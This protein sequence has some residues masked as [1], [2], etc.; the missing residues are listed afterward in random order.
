MT[1][2]SKIIAETHTIIRTVSGC[3]KPA[4]VQRAITDSLQNPAFEKGMNV[5]WELSNADLS[6][7]NDNEILEVIDFIRNSA[8]VRGS[9]YKIAIVASG[10]LAYG[11]SRMFEGLGSELPVA[12]NVHRSMAEAYDWVTDKGLQHA[13][14]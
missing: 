6:Q 3:F 13:L 4:D 14:S 11:I 1:V 2:E 9:H 7:I 10:D 5:I 8:D 12:I